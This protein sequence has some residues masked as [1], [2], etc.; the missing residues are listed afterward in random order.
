MLRP[1]HVLLGSPDDEA[2]RSDYESPRQPTAL[3]RSYALCEREVTRAEFERF[4]TATNTQGLPNIDE[5]SPLGVE[6]VV[7]PT[8]FEA[9]AYADWLNTQ[10]MGEDLAAGPAGHVQ[11]TIQ[12][13]HRGRMGVRLPRRNDH[14]LRFGSD[15]DLL[16]EYAWYADN[17]DLKTHGAGLL[18][19]NPAG[20]L[21]IHGQCWEWCQDWYRPYGDQPRVDPTGPEDGDRKVLRGGCWNLGPRYARSACR[22]TRVRSNRDYY[23]TFRLAITIPEIDPHGTP[24]R[25]DPLPS[26]G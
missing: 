15:R 7:A 20:L 17:S 22:N 13:A 23:I 8:W 6:P 16:G 26:T 25:P 18:R 9:T 24:D 21:N 12:A 1:G 11:V 19:P 14:R 5:W 10:M 2:E 3:T 4:M